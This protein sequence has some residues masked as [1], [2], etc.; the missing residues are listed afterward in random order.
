MKFV[1]DDG[2]R[3]AAGFRGSAGD[4]VVRAIA[5][6][7]EKPYREVYDALSDGCRSE[8]KGRLAKKK[9][10][11][12]GVAVRRKWFRDYMVSIGWKWTPTMHIGSGCKVHLNERELPSGRLIVAVSKHY[13]AVVDGVIHDTYNPSERD[14]TIYSPHFP[15]NELPK[16]A[17][18]L[19]NGNGWAYSPERCVY[20][21]Y[22]KSI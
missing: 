21:Y 4:C 2:G 20:G 18:W 22:A 14:T 10:A 9:S 16:N 7:T 19:E 1:F 5:I 11:R 15:V 8:R 12:D 17:R 6:A 3:Q 13:T